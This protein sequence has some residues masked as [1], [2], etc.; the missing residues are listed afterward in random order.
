MNKSV[1][2][3]FLAFI[4]IALRLNQT[5]TN[6]H[7]Y[8]QGQ[9][10]L[11]DLGNGSCFLKLYVTP[12]FL[13]L[14]GRDEVDNMYDLLSLTRKTPNKLSNLHYCRVVNINA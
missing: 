3:K 10:N 12:E 9:T 2:L 8:L 11:C 13:G 1:T 4:G 6:S 7:L 5:Q 14:T